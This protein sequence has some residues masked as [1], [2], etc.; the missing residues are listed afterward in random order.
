MKMMISRCGKW[1]LLLCLGIVSLPLAG[2]W[3]RKEIN[4]LALVTAAGIDKTDEEMIELSVQV[5]VPRSGGGGQL[6]QTGGTGSGPQSLVRSA[7]GKTVAEAMARLQERIPRTI[8]WGHTEV[9]IF[10]EAKDEMLNP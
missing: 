2:C 8:F 4:D 7:A 3:D 5:F 6:G 1:I 10:G 9:F